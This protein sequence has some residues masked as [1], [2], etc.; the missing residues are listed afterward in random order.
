MKNCTP[1]EWWTS[2]AAALF[3]L[4]AY[5]QIFWEKHGGAECGARYRE[6]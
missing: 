4:R 5:G 3:K 2:I 1:P 6:M